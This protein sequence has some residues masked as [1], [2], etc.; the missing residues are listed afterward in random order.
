MPPMGGG[1]FGSCT[2]PS[3]DKKLLFEAVQEYEKYV[4]L[5][6][7]INKIKQDTNYTLWLPIELWDNIIIMIKNDI[8]KMN[9]YDYKYCSHW[10]YNYHGK[11][12]LKK[13][14]EYKKQEDIVQMKLHGSIDY[15]VF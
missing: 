2:L 4:M 3:I 6:L 15:W 10:N 7:C 1:L 9:I 13:L 11:L 14:I 8:E 12:T 5:K